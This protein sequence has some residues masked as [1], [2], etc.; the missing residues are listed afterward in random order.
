[1]SGCSSSLGARLANEASKEQ[2]PSE[3]ENVPQDSEVVG[4]G[5]SINQSKVGGH[6]GHYFIRVS[7]NDFQKFLTRPFFIKETISYCC[8]CLASR[9]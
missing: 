1:M 6:D 2:T 5:Y 4:Q 9:E 8:F 7:L 3:V